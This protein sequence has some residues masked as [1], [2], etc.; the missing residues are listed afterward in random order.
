MFSVVIV[1]SFV[2]RAGPF[3]PYP[4]DQRAGV[5]VSWPT[6]PR[7]RAGAG[8]P[9]TRRRASTPVFRGAIENRILRPWNGRWL[10][11]LS[12]QMPKLRRAMP[13]S[14]EGLR[15]S[16]WNLNYRLLRQVCLTG[17]KIG[18][19]ANISNSSPFTPPRRRPI[20][21]LRRYLCQPQS[22]T[23]FSRRLRRIERR[24]QE[25]GDRRTNRLLRRLIRC[26]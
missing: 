6:R 26:A 7:E 19:E 15:V 16:I 4:P 22:V 1:I 5:D 20:R 12:P 8:R 23:A 25:P 18:V 10:K 11:L 3:Q 13:L 9:L 2:S 14:P 21:S 17:W 24:K